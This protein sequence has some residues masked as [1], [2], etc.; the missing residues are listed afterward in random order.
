[1]YRFDFDRDDITD[2]EIEI[3][4]RMTIA[5]R[6]ADRSFEHSGGSTRHY[7]RDCLLPMLSYHGIDLRLSDL[8]SIA[9]IDWENV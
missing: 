5:M 1:M 4:R 2:E 7:L 9:C 8:S 6:Q 3:L